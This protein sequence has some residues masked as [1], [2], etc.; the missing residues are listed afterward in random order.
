MSKIEKATQNKANFRLFAATIS[1]YWVFINL[2][3]RPEFN[4]A[5]IGIFL[6]CHAVTIARNR[7][8][9]FI[10]IAI[11]WSYLPRAVS[12]VTLTLRINIIL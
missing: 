10:C 3:R 7:V 9:I 6:F 5:I 12:S 2:W 1:K 11:F 8:T 4:I